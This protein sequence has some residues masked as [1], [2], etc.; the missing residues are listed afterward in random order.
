MMEWSRARFNH[1]A[2]AVLSLTANMHT[3]DCI[4]EHGY[5]LYA[6]MVVFTTMIISLYTAELTSIVLQGESSARRNIRGLVRSGKPFSVVDGG[7]SQQ[8]A[9]EYPD[10]DYN[11]LPKI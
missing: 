4:T 10:A 8:L 3:P 9:F 1:I 5:V 7:P 11:V 6:N 2:Y